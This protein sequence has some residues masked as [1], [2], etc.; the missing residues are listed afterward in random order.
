MGQVNKRIRL[1]VYRKCNGHCAY[2]GIPIE[3]KGTA[4]QVDHLDPVYWNHKKGTDNAL[5]AKRGTDDFTNLMPTC[6]RCNRWKGED[7]IETFRQRIWDQVDIVKEAHKGFNLL[8]DYGVI[9]MGSWDGK[10]YFE[11]MPGFSKEIKR[12]T[13]NRIYDNA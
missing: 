5:D 2:C 9:V 7:D 11:G 4:F 3:F 8:M 13:A 6:R 1:Q 12:I 10:F